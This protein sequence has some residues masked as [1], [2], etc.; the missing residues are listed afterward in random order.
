MNL[1]HLFLGLTLVAVPIGLIVGYSRS[2]AAASTADLDGRPYR[3][4]H[5]RVNRG[6]NPAEVLQFVLREPS[7]GPFTRDAALSRL[8][9]GVGANACDNARLLEAVD[10][11]LSLANGPDALAIREM[12]SRLA[13]P[14]R[15]RV[16]PIDRL[17]NNDAAWARMSERDRN[18]ERLRFLESDE[19]DALR[20]DARV[21]RER[22]SFFQDK[23]QAL[24]NTLVAA[25]KN[26]WDIRPAIARFEK[27]LAD[28]KGELEVSGRMREAFGL[29][30]F[31][32]LVHQGLLADRGSSYTE[33]DAAAQRRRCIAFADA[34]ALAERIHFDQPFAPEMKA[35]VTA[36]LSATDAGI[37][38]LLGALSSEGMWEAEGMRRWE[39]LRRILQRGL[40]DARRGSVVDPEEVCFRQLP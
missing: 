13:A 15:E 14:V 9:A 19:I 2:R 33:E 39:I 37:A 28:L 40:E 27:E 22:V 8:R 5:D 3:C 18:I 20:I 7:T 23:L 35:E 16:E 36:R 34:I 24:E 32:R 17:L 1:K 11:F 10:A 4:C 21:L 12:L 29:F 38:R 31:S 6:T 26:R 25:L 30:A